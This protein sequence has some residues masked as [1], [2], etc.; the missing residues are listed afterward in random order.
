MWLR[1]LVKALV[2]ANT[3]VPVI[4]DTV[5]AVTL[6]VKAATGSG[7]TVR[8]RAEVIRSEIAG[9]DAYGHAEVARLEA[10][11]AAEDAG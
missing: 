8:E 11:I 9:N 4:L 3:A 2:T 10:K 5:G 1:E 6:L 7:P